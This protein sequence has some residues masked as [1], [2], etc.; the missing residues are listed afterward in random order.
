VTGRCRVQW[1]PLSISELVRALASG[2]F[3]WWVAGGHALDL[4]PD[5]TTRHH[6]DLKVEALQRDQHQAQ[7]LLA[8]L[9]TP[10]QH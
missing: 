4:F 6:D 1:A 10:D 7:D 2:R 3:A 8:S 5:R 9:A